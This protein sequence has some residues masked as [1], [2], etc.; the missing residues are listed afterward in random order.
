MNDYPTVIRVGSYD[1]MSNLCLI[2]ANISHFYTSP[3]KKYTII[4]LTNGKRVWSTSGMREIEC[5]IKGQLHYV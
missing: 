4:F 1:G 2:V 3:D 5:M